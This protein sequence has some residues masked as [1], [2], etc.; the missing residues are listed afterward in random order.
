MNKGTLTLYVLVTVGIVF[1]V[2]NPSA[3]NIQRT[4]GIIRW[5]NFMASGMVG[6]QLKDPSGNDV[7]KIRDFVIDPATGRV[8]Y[9]ILSQIRGMEAKSIAVPFSTISETPGGQ[10]LVYHP[11]EVA[12]KYYGQAPYWSE[13]F[14]LYANRSTLMGSQEATKL[15]GATVRA[16]TGEVS[17]IKDLEIYGIDGSVYAVFP[18]SV[19]GNKRVVR[20]PMSWMPRSEDDTFLLNFVK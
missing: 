5:D 3:K 20:V 2:G 12:E 19:D 1:V 17:Q 8:S 9:V 4:T 16:T 13:G 10:M 11:T 14:Y 6:K 7:A 18:F 15:I